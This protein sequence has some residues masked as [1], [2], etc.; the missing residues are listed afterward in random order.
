MKYINIIIENKSRH[1]DNFFTYRTDCD[2]I[3]V[4]AKVLV[5]FGPKDRPREGFVFGITDNPECPEEKIKDIL[6]V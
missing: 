4:G 2:D 5:P 1:T 6:T 3:C